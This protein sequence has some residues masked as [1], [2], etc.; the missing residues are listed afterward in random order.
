M[1]TAVLVLI[2]VGAMPLSGMAQASADEGTVTKVLALEHA[3][4]QAVKRKDINALA[5]VLDDGL[6]SVDYDGT[7]RNKAEFLA[8][9][10]AAQTHPEQEVAD[11]MTALMI[12]NT[13]VVTGLY[14]S[15]GVENGKPYVRRGRF[16]D[17]WAFRNG[18]WLCVVSQATPIVH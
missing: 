16:V 9:V 15:R 14:T 2:L 8:K 12:F 7:L 10:K 1:K 18:I 4:D 5:Q 13:V 6:V 17:T 11:D 3:W